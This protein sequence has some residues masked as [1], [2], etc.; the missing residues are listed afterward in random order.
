MRATALPIPNTYTSDDHHVTFHEANDL[1]FATESEIFGLT[2]DFGDLQCR[3]TDTRH[4]ALYYRSLGN[5]DAVTLLEAIE[6]RLTWALIEG[7]KS[8]EY[9]PIRR[10]QARR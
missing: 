10:G 7:H 3:I 1:S 8:A 9:S 2:E 4:A 6:R 5:H